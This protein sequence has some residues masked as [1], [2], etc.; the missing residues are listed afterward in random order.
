MARKLMALIFAIIVTYIAAAILLSQL[1]IAQVIDMGFEVSLI[2]RLTSAWHDLAGML[3]LYL[4]IIAVALLIAFLFTS[5]LLL[6]FINKSAVLFSLAGFVGLMT[7]HFALNTIFGIAAI[8]PTRTII[9][10]LSQ[11][12]AG[13][14]GGYVYYR[15]SYSQV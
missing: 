9:G 11:G 7:V 14:I 5:L 6:R 4:P 10:F 8:A 12:L 15:L 2:Q 1:N 13:A 3:D